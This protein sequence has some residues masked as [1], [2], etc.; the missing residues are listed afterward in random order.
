MTRHPTALRTKHKEEKPSTLTLDTTTTTMPTPTRLGHNVIKTGL[1]KISLS[2]SRIALADIAAKLHL[3]SCCWS[4]GPFFSSIGGGGGWM[5]GGI[6][7]LFKGVCLCLSF[8]LSVFLSVWM[9]RWIDGSMDGWMDGW[10]Y[11]RGAS[12]PLSTAL[13]PLG[14]LRDSVTVTASLTKTKPP[15]TPKHT[16]NQTQS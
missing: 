8:C 15:P 10:I 12:S 14:P 11:P 4:F 13:V 9:D 5:G 2:Y 7:S 6:L 16:T 3:V 1:R